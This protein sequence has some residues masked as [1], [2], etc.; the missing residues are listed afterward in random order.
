MERAERVA[1]AVED[2]ERLHEQFQLRGM[3]WCGSGLVDHLLLLLSAVVVIVE[4][5]ERGEVVVL[6]ETGSEEKIWGRDNNRRWECSAGGILGP[7]GLLWPVVLGS[8]EACGRSCP[9]GTKR[10]GGSFCRTSF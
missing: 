9:R 6:A 7:S 3:L 8:D 10:C 5:G 1:V 2:I 4:P